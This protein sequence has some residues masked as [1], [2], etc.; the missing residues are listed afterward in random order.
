MYFINAG[1]P[2]VEAVGKA[3]QAL[4]L[5][6]YMN[7]STIVNT[8]VEDD[9]IIW[10]AWHEY[11]NREIR[12]HRCKQGR[13]IC[14]SLGQMEMS[15]IELEWLT[16]DFKLL[17]KGVLDYIFFG[18]KDAYEVYKTRHENVRWFPYPVY[19]STNLL[20]S[21]S[22]KIPNSVGI[23]LPSTPRKNILNQKAAC[24]LARRSILD[25]QVFTNEK[26]WLPEKEYY[27]LL[28]KMRIVLNITHVESFSYATIDA[29]QHGVLPI[30]SPCVQHNLD[31]PDEV[32]VSNPDSPLDISGMLITL[33]RYDEDIYVDILS[34][35]TRA[36]ESLAKRNNRALGEL[37]ALL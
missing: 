7:V 15:G 8:I 14:S 10:G 29:I 21:Q 1:M 26:G 22:T 23:F 2:G 12:K 30:V 3:G 20:K 35:C 11:Y 28:G 16:Y 4:G 9:F 32:M 24:E 5:W 25:L 33:L 27:E 34:K 31:L 18:S 6:K 36:I 37:L 19:Q 13:L 17:E